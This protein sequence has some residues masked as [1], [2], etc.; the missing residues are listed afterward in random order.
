MRSNMRDSTMTMYALACVGAQTC[1]ILDIIH[2]CSSIWPIGDPPHPDTDPRR[3]QSLP[4]I[5]S[6]IKQD[7]DIFITAKVTTRTLFTVCEDHNY[8]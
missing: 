1:S 3:P 7:C 2:C 6:F 5:H 4:N 8:L